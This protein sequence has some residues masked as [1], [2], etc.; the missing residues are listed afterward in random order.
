[1]SKAKATAVRTR[2][3]ILGTI[4]GISAFVGFMKIVGTE[5]AC[6]NSGMSSSDITTSIIIGVI[7]V[8]FAV[9]CGLFLDYT[10]GIKEK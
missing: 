4:G 6:K 9:L 2:R 5:G 7:L 10:S 8:V 3:N 1:M